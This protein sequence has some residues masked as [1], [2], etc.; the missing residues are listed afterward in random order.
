MSEIF[1]SK[2]A[3]EAKENIID[4][5][6]LNRSETSPYHELS[7]QEI[8]DRTCDETMEQLTN[9]FKDIMPEEQL[10][11]M[12]IENELYKPSVMS[13]EEYSYRFPEADPS[14]LG[15]C[16]ET[17]R[18]YL[19]DSSPE[20]IRHVVTHE[21]MHRAS[22][23]ETDDSQIGVETYRSGIREVVL[24]EGRVVEDNNQALNE[25]ITELYAL[26]EMQRRGEVSAIESVN[27]YPE[28]CQKVFELQS[29][30]G[31]EVLE[32][33]Y[34]GGDTELV[35]SEVIRLNCGEETTWETYS[36]HVD[37]LEYGTDPNQIRESKK[38]LTLLQSIM[39]ANKEVFMYQ[40]PIAEQP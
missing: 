5:R 3:K 18:I 14:V 7:S 30:V 17:G 36:K 39:I 23:K 22:F 33:A 34:F 10:V 31:S 8:A 27:A 20:V 13:S 40:R 29:I 2:E 19:K 9:T 38:E 12:D 24:H 21:T 1:S 16:D 15:H 35:S 26:K 11:R 25:G 37:V 28:A 4:G 32:K 6:E